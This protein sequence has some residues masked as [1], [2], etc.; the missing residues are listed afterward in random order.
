MGL[1]FYLFWIQGCAVQI[2]LTVARSPTVALY[3]Y[4]FIG[5]TVI[6]T[7]RVMITL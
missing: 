3:D 7:P 2:G 4:F 5:I 6:H 1:E